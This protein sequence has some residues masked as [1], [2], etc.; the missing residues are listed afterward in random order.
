MCLLPRMKYLWT[1]HACVL[2]AYGVCGRELWLVLLNVLH[3]N[4]KTKVHTPP[5]GP[6]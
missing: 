5:L 6:Q 2:A 3:W 4:S 1:G